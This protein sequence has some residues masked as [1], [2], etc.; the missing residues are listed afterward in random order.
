MRLL[1]VAGRF[2][3]SKKNPKKKLL[4]LASTKMEDIEDDSGVPS[5]FTGSHLYT[6]ATIAHGTSDLRKPC[7]ILSTK[8]GYRYFFGS[9]P[10]GTQRILNEK[11]VRFPKLRSLFLTGILDDWS[12]I[13]GLPGMFL[14]VGDITKKGL[15]VIVNSSKIAH[16]LVSTWRYFVFRKGVEFKIIEG[17]SPIVDGKITVVPVKI[18]NDIQSTVDAQL[19]NKIHNQLQKLT[20]LMFPLDTSKVNSADPESYTSDPSTDALHVHTKL[21]EFSQ[22][23]TAVLQ[24]SMNYI[25][26]FAPNRGKFNPKRAIE[27]GVPQGRSFAML[28]KGEAVE[29]K[30]GEMV[31][32]EQ[33]ME[34]PLY[35]PRVAIIDI[36]NNSYLKCTLESQVWFSEDHINE[37]EQ[38]GLVYHLL[39]PD[40]DY[41]RPEYHEFIKKFPDDCHHVI[42]HPLFAD[43]T[44][45]HE[46]SAITVLKLKCLQ[47]NNFNLPY[48]ED[49]K[50]L[51]GSPFI[52]KLQSCQA[53]DVKPGGVQFDDSFVVKHSWEDMFRRHIEPISQDYEMQEVINNEPVSLTN[54][55]GS[56]KD[57]VQVITLGTG[58]ALPSIHRNVISSV[59]RV[60][61][62][63]N[64]QQIYNSVMFDG[65]ENTL[66]TMLR[67]FGHN[68]KE[69]F[70]QVMKELKMIYLSHLHADHHLG[71]ISVVNEWFKYNADNKNLLYLV[72]PWQYGKF[73]TEWYQL[74]AEMTPDID[75]SRLRYISCEEFLNSGR[76]IEQIT[77][78]EF[79]R[80]YDSKGSQ[81]LRLLRGSINEDALTELK[82][83]LNI[84]RVEMARALHCSWAYSCSFTFNLNEAGEKFK[85][86]YSGDT[87]PNAE[88][89]NSGRDSDLLI[90]EASLDNGLMEEAIAKKHSTVIEAIEVAR[91]MNCRN[92]LLTHFS[93][94]YK[95]TSSMIFDPR[96]MEIE[97]Q[98][99]GEYLEKT[100]V[101][102]N[103]FRSNYRD[104]VLKF[105]DLNLTFA[106]DFMIM[107]LDEMALQKEKYG[108]FLKVFPVA[109]EDCEKRKERELKRRTRTTEEKRSK[110][111]SL[112]NSS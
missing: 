11:R 33:V 89:V 54:K 18:E 36:P 93:T 110:R 22:M 7:V 83:D 34:A 76:E 64:G 51:E 84:D 24:P 87:R 91:Q 25:V 57:Q 103:I 75:M 90:H 32:P 1:K 44:L 53:F 23:V 82:K 85:V 43:N 99:L 74:E 56:L 104:S 50:P 27:L 26:K 98:K 71:I 92:L 95:E 16:Y 68:N 100:K 20:S 81:N 9:I 55:Q 69:H 3:S 29:S 14:T 94:R 58:S 66:G 102:G 2:L 30:T 112:K 38:Y 62:F 77:L 42:S 106:Y 31:Y 41:T 45:M 4:V 48:F 101:K 109:E 46:T 52:H 13:G 37:R 15:E 65:G 78:D 67:A 72:F 8:D 60:P 49:Y 35:L 59:V 63:E 111:L 47:R 39:G 21:P 108:E 40:V 97:A 86:S 96:R 79:E 5:P 107:R 61:R 12:R 6:F 10:E 80:L 73:L 17:S 88:F 28:T 70:I 19:S 105:D